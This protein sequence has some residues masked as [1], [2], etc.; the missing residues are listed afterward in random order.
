M[1]ILQVAEFNKICRLCLKEDD[2]LTNVFLSEALGPISKIT[3]IVLEMGD[4]LPENVCLN[5]LDKAMEFHN[6]K[7]ICEANDCALKTALALSKENKKTILEVTEQTLLAD[8]KETFHTNQLFTQ[9]K[10]ARKG[11]LEI[12]CNYKTLI[13]L[14]IYNSQQ[15]HENAANAKMLEVGDSEESPVEAEEITEQAP[16]E[17]ITREWCDHCQCNLDTSLEAHLKDYHPQDGSNYCHLC[18]KGSSSVYATTKQLKA[19]LKYHLQ[20][21]KLQCEECGKW[22]KYRQQKLVH[23]RIHTG[24]RPAVCHVCSKSFRDSRYLAVHLKSHTGERPYKCSICLKGFGHK[25]NLKLHLKTHTMERDHM[26]S[27]C[28]KTFIYA[29]NLKIHMRQ[30]TGEKPYSC[31]QCFTSFVSASVLNA[32]MLTHSD[33][34]RFECKVC[35]KRFKRTSYLTIHMRSHTGEKPYA[36]TLC[37]K[38][39][40]MSSHLTEHVKTHTGEKNYICDICSKPFYNNKALQVHKD[41]HAGKKTYSCT[42]CDKS[43][44]HHTSLYAHKRKQ[45]KDLKN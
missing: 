16:L 11:K 17:V 28:G 21:P 20:V 23:M 9:A 38:T 39:Y 7:L 33:H 5:C 1:P 25:F 37:G 14:G 41:S 40:K 27:M 6:F 26:C 12:V 18:P 44:V 32:H 22:F 4:F 2:S 45:H 34:K 15:T 36:C 24:E 10:P 8:N 42:D 35:G 13:P 19:H 43:F 3:S 29:H 30:H 31:R